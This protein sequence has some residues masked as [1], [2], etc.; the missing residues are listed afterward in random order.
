[1]PT[2]MRTGSGRHLNK[3]WN[4]GAAHALYHKDGG[5]FHNLERFP[6][7]LCDPSGYVLFLDKESYLKS[8]YL[9]IGAHTTV[10]A[11][12]ANIPGYVQKRGGGTH[13]GTS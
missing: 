5:W 2:G 7:A 4:I 10:P 3:E 9:R 6:G 12:V 1:M 8:P 13:D 11:G